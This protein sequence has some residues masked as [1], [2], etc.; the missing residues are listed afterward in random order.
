MNKKSLLTVF[1]TLLA[2]VF[3]SACD[4]MSAS[5]EL[6]CPRD[7]KVSTT[8]TYGI[9]AVFKQTVFKVKEKVK[10]KEGE[11]LVFKLKPRGGMPRVPDFKDAEVRIK[12]KTDNEENAWFTLITGS[13]NST[14]SDGHTL[15]ICADTAVDTDEDRTY[16]YEIEIVGFGKLD[17][18]VIV[19]PS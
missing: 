14:K 11:G 9:G 13:Y 5:Q 1:G 12:G 8:I 19:E 2:A 16:E 17:P 15:G 10:V 6:D 18:R 7:G 4:T 3:L